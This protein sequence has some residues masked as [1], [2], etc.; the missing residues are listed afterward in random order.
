MRLSEDLS[1]I[2]ASVPG[3]SRGGLIEI[4]VAIEVRLRE[5]LQIDY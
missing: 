2:R 1:K 3:V 4:E 5:E